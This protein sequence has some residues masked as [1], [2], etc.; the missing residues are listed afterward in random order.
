MGLP[1]PVKRFTPQEYYARE[2]AAAQKSEYYKGE[3]FAMAGGSKAH[4]EITINLG[5]GLWQRLQGRP[6]RPYDSNY[7]L[8]VIATG[9][10]CYPDVSVYCG[11]IEPDPEDPEAAT[12]TNPS[13]LFEV[14]SKS[15]EGY[16]RG[17]KAANYREI[18]SLRT[19]VLVAQDSPHVEAYDRQPDGSW[20]LREAKGL[21][22]TLS[23]P[24]I[25]V[26]LPL[27]EIYDRVE[28][29]PPTPIEQLS[30]PVRPR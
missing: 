17:F 11:P 28:F 3:I 15:T 9:L 20:R 19:Y 14:L 23:I 6:C 21:N 16:D 10:R 25:D 29:P 13:V 12:G 26:T 18:A 22:A 5:G 24:G 27:A 4:S 30:D 7:R 8:K 2:A 1:Q